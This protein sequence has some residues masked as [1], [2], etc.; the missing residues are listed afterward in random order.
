MIISPLAHMFPSDYRAALQ[1]LN[2]GRPLALTNHNE[3]SAS[4]KRFALQLAG[5]RPDQE[6]SPRVGLLGRLKQRGA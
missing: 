4:F 2:K 1:A 3:L 6:L 5:V